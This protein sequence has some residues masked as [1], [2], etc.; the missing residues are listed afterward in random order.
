MVGIDLVSIT[1][2]TAMLEASGQPYRDQCWTVDE[3]AY[4]AD[5]AARYAARWAAKEA[6]MKAL[7]HGIGE[8]EPT[9]IEV[10]AVEGQRPV[11]RL[12]G[13]ARAFADA[14]GVELVVSM[15]HEGAIATAVVIGTSHCN[16]H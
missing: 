5:S 16:G 7:G 15:S 4:C 6:A 8:I 10:V 11:L 3:Q 13:T 1:E 14:A 12:T 9:D 2:I